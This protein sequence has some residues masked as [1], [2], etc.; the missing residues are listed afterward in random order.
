MPRVKPFRLSQ[1]FYSYLE[2]HQVAVTS[3]GSYA[4]CTAVATGATY[5]V[6]I[7]PYGHQYDRNVLCSPKNIRVRVKAGRK[8]TQ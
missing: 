5:L 2:L 4:L 6:K 7:S 3:R 8:E 1:E